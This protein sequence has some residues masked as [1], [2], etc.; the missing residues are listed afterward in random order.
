MSLTYLLD[1][2]RS[3][4]QSE[5]CGE[6]TRNVALNCTGQAA[7]HNRRCDPEPSS[8]EPLSWRDRASTATTSSTLA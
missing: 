7:E 4:V 8:S 5:P 1:A 3:R 6:V 2:L